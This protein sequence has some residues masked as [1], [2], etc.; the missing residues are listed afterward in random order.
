MLKICAAITTVIFYFNWFHVTSD[1]TLQ[2][3]CPRLTLKYLEMKYHHFFYCLCLLLPAPIIVL[4]TLI[5]LG[6][7]DYVYY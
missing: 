5:V 1:I 4:V 6:L 2:L 7:I 3:S